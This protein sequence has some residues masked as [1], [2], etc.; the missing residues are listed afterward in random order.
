MNKKQRSKNRKKTK[1]K[2][3]N[4]NSKISNKIDSTNELLSKEKIK[5]NEN[6]IIQTS[7]RMIF[8]I[9][10]GET[11]SKI[12]IDKLIAITV[13]ICENKEREKKFDNFYFDYILN[14]M[15]KLFSINSIFHTEEPEKD[16]SIYRENHNLFTNLL[17]IN[18][19][20][21]K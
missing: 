11:I 8:P 12:I 21:Y 16:E 2:Q 19:Y 20:F 4:S 10:L 14:Q 5:E 15:D 3:Q 9:Q 7:K 6:N 18:D 1:S 17:N 13:R